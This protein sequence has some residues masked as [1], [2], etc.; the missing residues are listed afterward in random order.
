MT[1]AER[2]ARLARDSAHRLRAL[3]TGTSFLVQAPAGSGK[4]ELLIQ[5]YLALLARVESP[6]RVVAMT[7]TRKAASEMRERVVGALQ[8]ARDNAPVTSAHAKVTRALAA[9]VLAQAERRGWSL[10]A[11]PAQLSIFTIDALSGMLARQSPVTSSMGASPRIVERAEALHAEAARATLADADPADPAWRTL[12]AHLDNNAELVVQLLSSMLARREQW[13]RHVVGH[14]EES[15]RARVEAVLRAEIAA[16]L[17]A[18][19]ARFPDALL[20]SIAR[21]A[22][23]AAEVLREDGGDEALIEALERCLAHGGVPRAQHDDIAAWRGVAN[24]L[25]VAKG[26]ARKKMDRRQGVRPASADR[27]VQKGEVEA[28][29]AALAEAPETVEALA[30][31]RDLPDATF[32]DADWA[33]VAALLH[34]LPLAAAQLRLTFAQRGAVDFAELNAAAAQ[35]ARRRGCAERAPA[36]PRS[37]HRASPGRR[38]PGHVRRAVRPHRPAHRGMGT[39]RRPHALRGRRSDAVDLPLSRCRGAA[40]P[41]GHRGRRASATCPSSSSTCRATSVRRPRSSGG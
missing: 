36:A 14:E 24:W 35:C 10:L 16:E 17:T 34:V 3:D 11:H 4:T 21:C 38:V 8:A 18:A 13:L 7:F 19:R 12:L 27:G 2:D 39:R 33:I 40:L 26:D 1:D 6:Q 25:L 32:T 31:A 5:R 41:R 28:M 9:A 20:A 37:H 15:L 30:L 23:R 29:L 22:G